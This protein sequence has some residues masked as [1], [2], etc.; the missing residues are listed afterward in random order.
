MTAALFAHPSRAKAEITVTSLGSLGGGQT[1]PTAINN[2]G[3]IV[4]GSLTDAEDWH[5]FIWQDGAMTDLG[6]APGDNH[7]FAFAVN[8][9]GQVAGVSALLGVNL[10]NIDHAVVWRDGQMTDVGMYEGL[11]TIPYNI[12]ETGQIAGDYYDNTPGNNTID[13]GFV[14]QDGS[15]TDIGGF[16]GNTL[17]FD[18]NNKGQVAGM[19]RD[20]HAPYAFIWQDGE[21][22]RLSENVSWAYSIN[23]SGQVVGHDNTDFFGQAFIW[24]K[25]D[26]T[27][28]GTA[29]WLGSGAN[30]VNDCGQVVGYLINTF[31]VLHPFIWQ[32]GVI[33]DLGTA[34]G[35]Y[36]QATGL[37]NFGQ[38]IG[39]TYNN[40]IFLQHPCIW[41]D[42]V[43]TELVKLDGNSEGLGSAIAI[44]DLGQV[45]GISG[46]EAVIWNTRKIVGLAVIP[47]EGFKKTRTKKADSITVAVLGSEV[48]DATHVDPSTVSLSGAKVGLD[49]YGD[50]L[51]NDEDVNYDGFLDRVF[52]VDASSLLLTKHDTVAVLQ[53]KTYE[54]DPI[55]GWGPVNIKTE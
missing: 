3:Q 25:G 20:Q 10:F 29:G 28:L 54:G 50:W 13:G 22:T 23:E 48:F 1:Y 40:Y 27:H 8:D 37:N 5:A 7:S 4:G 51:Y 47:E 11:N 21:I 41:Q 36:A 32:D 9:K 43:I 12:N 55:S 45:V 34:G 15:F 52:Q 19:S 18:L 30:A 53:G 33:S 35:W 39:G 44:N 24:Q 46:D 38:V 17:V 42:G 14:W 6:T 26:L 49:D 2:K 31:E 16:G